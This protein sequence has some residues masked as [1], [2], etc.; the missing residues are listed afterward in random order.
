MKIEL[1]RKQIDGIARAANAVVGRACR[2]PVLEHLHFS[3]MSP[4]RLDVTAA[5]L[6]QRLTVTVV[7]DTAASPGECLVPLGEL[8]ALKKTLGRSGTVTI[9]TKS[10]EELVFVTAT[11]AGCFERTVGSLPVDEFPLPADPPA[12]KEADTAGFLT[13]YRRAAA[14]AST[15]ATRGALVG[16]YADP[17]AEALVGTDGRRLA[18]LPLDDFPFESDAILPVTKALLKRIPASGPG[19]IGLADR[20]HEQVF[21]IRTDDL[22]YTCKCLD[23]PFPAYDR[24]IPDD[25][26]R[27]RTTLTF[28]EADADALKT[29]LPH[30]KNE[31]NRPVFLAGRNGAVAAG[32]DTDANGAS[33]LVLPGCRFDRGAEFAVAVNGTFLESALRSGFRVLRVKDRLTP[34]C[35]NGDNG[36]LHLVMPLRN[37]PP[38]ALT[39]RLDSV[40]KETADKASSVNVRASTA[41]TTAGPKASGKT[42]R[43]T[44][45]TSAA[46]D[47]SDPVARLD[48]LVTES[49]EAIRAARTS[50]TELG[51]QVRAVKAHYRNREKEIRSREKE[52]EKNLALISR[53]QESV[54]A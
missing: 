34:L 38:E 53:L 12:M 43:V 26:D 9:G 54:A 18:R 14:S 24:V 1:T 5:D 35:F 45:A 41:A 7:P 25:L 13:A 22:Q 49:R 21:A 40:L 27:F 6:E 20:G 29:L 3:V 4:D 23:G 50:V 10:E 39:A 31:E 28:G 52:M 48:E 17:K 42:D 30:V 15:D 8:K 37:E 33:A 51:K 32:I 47:A 36:G 46:S 16:V 44:A 11:G 2:L 19:M